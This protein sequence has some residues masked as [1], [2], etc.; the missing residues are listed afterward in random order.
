M[1]IQPYLA[2]AEAALWQHAL[3]APLTVDL[4]ESAAAL[5]DRISL[6]RDQVA[7]LNDDHGCLGLRLTGT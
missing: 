2:G 1:E 5:T 6:N 4:G 7:A 3:G